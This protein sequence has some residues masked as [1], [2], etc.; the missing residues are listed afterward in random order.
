M[1]EH[2]GAS[3][4]PRE[5]GGAGIRAA[6]LRPPVSQRGGAGTR[7]GRSR[8][9]GG[10]GSA[11]GNGAGARPAARGDAGG[12]EGEKKKLKEAGCVSSEL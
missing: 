6:V 8:Q 9:K 12:K 5:A 3:R 2:G 10:A 7:P 4:P 11:R 1:E